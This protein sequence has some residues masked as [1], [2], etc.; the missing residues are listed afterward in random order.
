MRLQLSNAVM[1]CPAAKTVSFYLVDGTYPR[2][3]RELAGT[4]YDVKNTL[5]KN[6]AIAM[7]IHSVVNTMLRPKGN[8]NSRSK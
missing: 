7:I 3:S 1:G 4:L 6:Y 8:S 5:E 2:S